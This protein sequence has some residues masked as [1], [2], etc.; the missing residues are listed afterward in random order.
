MKQNCKLCDGR[1]YCI[2]NKIKG[3]CYICGGSAL[4]ITCKIT[5]KSKIY[6]LGKCFSN[7]SI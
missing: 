1:A 7:G 4:C 3:R 2:H 6:V 5:L